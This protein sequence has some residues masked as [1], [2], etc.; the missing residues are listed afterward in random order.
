MTNFFAP[1]FLYAIPSKKKFTFF[2]GL[3]VWYDVIFVLASFCLKRDFIQKKKKRKKEGSRKRKVDLKLYFPS[4]KFL[5]D[6]SSLLCKE[7]FVFYS[8]I[9]RK[10]TGFPGSSYGICALNEGSE[11]QNKQKKNCISIRHCE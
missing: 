11:T 6:L 1:L 2:V 8:F 10:Q 7:K 5:F 9:V 4:E 3:F